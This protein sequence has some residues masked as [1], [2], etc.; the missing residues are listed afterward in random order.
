MWISHSLPRCLF[1]ISQL[2]QVTGDILDDSIKEIFKYW[3][4]FIG[5]ATETPFSLRF[6]KLY[7]TSV[8]VIEFSHASLYINVDLS[9]Q[10]CY[11]ILI[12]AFSANFTTILIKSYKPRR[13]T[14]SVMSV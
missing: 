2:T 6:P 8:K 3:N 13:V 10:L 12:S 9:L 7:F 14:R 1:E 4:L 5:F 11:I